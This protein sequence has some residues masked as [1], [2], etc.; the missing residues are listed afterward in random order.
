[1]RY[2]DDY[3]YFII[4]INLSYTTDVYIVR[5]LCEFLG[6]ITWRYFMFKTNI[7]DTVGTV[8][9]LVI[10]MQSNKKSKVILMSKFIQSNGWTCRVGRVLPHNKVCEYSLYKTLLMMDRCGLK[11]VELT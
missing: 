1:M 8:Y 9:H 2:N 11:H 3:I 6:H 7:L 5:T 10:Y 4:E